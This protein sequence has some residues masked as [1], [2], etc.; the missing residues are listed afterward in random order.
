VVRDR[1]PGLYLCNP[2]ICGFFESRG[3][4]LAA[5]NTSSKVVERVMRAPW[6]L[7]VCSVVFGACRPTPQEEITAD[8]VE[9]NNRAVGLMGQFDFAA[10]VE[11]FDAIQTSAPAWPGARLNLA[12]ALMNRQGTSD[13]ARAEALLRDLLHVQAV[14]R[15][16][17]YSL[18]LL[19]VHE[20]REAEALPLL[21]EVANGD[22]PDGFAAYFVGQL[23]LAEAPAEALDW[24]RRAFTLQPLLRSAYY[25][26]FLASRR[27]SREDE[28][29]AMLSRFQALERHPQAI[30]AEFKYTRMGPLSEAIT[31]DMPDSRPAATPS[32]PRFQRSTPLI[33]DTAAWR[34]DGPPRSITAADIDADGP[35]DLFVADAL[36]G[37]RPNAV[38]LGRP[39]L[40]AEA[41]S[42][43]VEDY[44]L[45]SAH[46]LAAISGVRA[47]LW[48]DL[49]DDGLVDVVLCRPNGGTRLWK[50]ASGGQW[51]DV[52]AAS[53]IRFARTNIVDG[54]LFDADHDGDLDVWLVN[55]AGPNELLNNDGGVR[56]RAIGAT[57]GVSG[58][59]RPS[60]GLAAADLD[61]DRDSDVIV[62]KESPPHDIFL[63]GR[64]WEYRRDEGA[65][66]ALAAAPISALVAGDFDAD[67]DVELYTSGERGIERW[68][69]DTSGSWRPERLA[70]PA[71]ADG[72]ERLA[73][74]DTNGDGTLELIASSGHGWAIYEPTSPGSDWAHVP[75][76]DFGTAEAVPYVR[77][78]PRSVSAAPLGWAVAQLDASSGPSVVGVRDDGA[79]M[80]WRPG[81]G[82]HAFLAMRFSG[83]D[84]SSDQRR[85]N[86]SGLGTRVAL[87]AGSRW[88]AFDTTRL[89]S[90]PGQ[91][92]QPIAIGLAGA[93]RA[94]FV[95]ITWSDGVF[96]TEL[97]LD[98]GRL[99]AITETQR[100]LSS[101]PVLFAWDGSRYRFVTD[102]LGVGGIGFFERPGV[103]STP[104]PRESV[105]LPDDVVPLSDHA[106]RLK[107]AEPMEE[108]TYLD[109]ASLLAYDLPPGWQMALDERKAIA[110]PPPTGEPIFYR[111]ERLPARAVN[112]VGEDVTA[113]L[114]EADLAA[115]GPA[116]VDPRFI[117][118]A[119]PYAV[120]LTFDR[121]IGSGPGRPVLLIDGWV[122]YP[123]AQTVFAAWQ[124]GAVYEAPT[125]E[126]RDRDG[127]WHTVA[128]EFGYPAGMPRRM[129]FPLPSLPSGATAL[130]LRTSQEIYWDRIAIVYA[131]SAPDVR[132]H[133]L[134]LRSARL[135]A[136]GFAR[137]TTG[138][139]R[140]PFYDDL[141]RAPLADTRH[142]RGWYT[143]FG[144]VDPL[145]ADEDAAVVIFGPG[146]EVSLEFAAPAAPA[147]RGWKRQLVLDARGWCKDMDLYTRDGETIEPLPGRDTA[148]RTRLHARYNTRYASGY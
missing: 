105:L 111:E 117:G 80:V 91:S 1:P 127:R 100:Q 52:T 124:A 19:L 62:I 38:L 68:R 29:A 148:A 8:L 133:A 121:E 4:N 32:G 134:R 30:A 23:R 12:I 115:I 120:T 5:L 87:R 34:R 46:P 72:G 140:A 26:A 64:G 22:P 6:W 47:A 65:A 61:G 33:A 141:S 40:S 112:D 128:R 145:I 28:A 83:R 93:P 35:L 97:A 137:R 43:K 63:N 77:V 18:G 144:E 82:R 123:Y 60:R 7:L 67:G 49:D 146:E 76:E 21:M 147:P 70:Q 78:E 51:L 55:A 58:D 138:A 79:P 42:A 106:Y 132:R 50:Q 74:A 54:A 75:A 116:H 31:V 15:R 108:V 73:T 118:L 98:A 25:G 66:A 126:A 56:F 89:Q 136:G 95:A 36:D 27:S 135:E 110:G 10:A 107:I 16:A 122:E 17:R 92:L 104:Y 3:S 81:S 57:A 13:P 84:P 103:Y 142:P 101:C 88:T 9:R 99:H 109:R 45:D 48:G 69:R 44:F 71:R 41:R 139:Q 130:R 37:Q 94:D 11:A 125:L 2:F 113:A 129:T 14:A 39:G 59:G 119:R 24:Y 96:Q 102:V 53:G 90:G 85:S 114:V 86:V 131:E 143:E 20:G